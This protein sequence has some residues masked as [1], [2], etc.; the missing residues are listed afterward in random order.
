[1]SGVM[2]RL[3]AQ[4]TRADLHRDVGRG[5]GAMRLTPSR[6]ADRR[7]GTTGANQQWSGQPRRPQPPVRSAATR[8]AA[9]HRPADRHVAVA[10]FRAH[11]PPPRSGL[12]WRQFNATGR[13]VRLIG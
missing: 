5:F 12:A 2:A 10:P 9:E 13:T 7:S 3:R 4:G 1:M 11:R 6:S 8:A